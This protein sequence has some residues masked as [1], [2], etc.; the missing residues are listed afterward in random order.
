MTVFRTHHVLSPSL[1]TSR[2]GLQATDWEFVGTQLNNRES[3]LPTPCTKR[4]QNPIIRS[5]LLE[6]ILGG[7]EDSQNWNKRYRTTQS[8][9]SPERTKLRVSRGPS[10][11]SDLGYRWWNLHENLQRGFVFY[12][13]GVESITV[14]SFPWKNGEQGQR[15]SQMRNTKASLAWPDTEV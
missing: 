12:V 10:W 3:P 9:L 2:S 1:L 8:K 15:I 7:G 14:L 6:N 4:G 5:R 11:I 13:L